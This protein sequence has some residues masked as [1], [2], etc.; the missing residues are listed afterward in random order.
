MQI[1]EHHVKLTNS[2]RA[3][4]LTT[5]LISGT[6]APAFASDGG[7]AFSTADQAVATVQKATGTTDI[8]PDSTTGTVMATDR[9]LVTVTTGQR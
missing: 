1:R 2:V 4:L 6:V 9:G 5:A 8:A 3:A 7:P